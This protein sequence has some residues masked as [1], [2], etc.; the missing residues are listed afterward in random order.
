MLAE[1]TQIGADHTGVIAALKKAASATGVDFSYLLSTAT[2]ESSLKTDAQSTTSSASGLF[3][4]VDQ[5]W[6]GL[7]KNYG[8]K[9]GL[10]SMAD[11]IERTPEGHYRADN[12]SDRQAILSLR[13]DPQVSALM[14]GEYANETRCQMK[15]SLGRD[16]CQG[17]LY[18]AHFLGPQAAC[19]L[20]QANNVQPGESAASIFP[21][22][23][24]ANRSV[25]FHSDGSAKSISEVY[26]WATRGGQ[27]GLSSQMA[28][29]A[30]GSRHHAKATSVPLSLNGRGDEDSNAMMSLASWTPQHGFFS[31]D[32]S[33]NASPSSTLLLTPSV[34]D[35]LAQAKAMAAKAH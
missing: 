34:M 7:I 31:S 26:Q 4:F 8:A 15:S 17:E 21:Q 14:E 11:A 2:R 19:K 23:A 16:V 3:Q 24:E 20:I 29:I 1:A 13:K 27:S 18:A 22:A 35:I 32:T 5:T 12:S 6:L 33:E 25:F 30:R 10:G 28:S 9:F